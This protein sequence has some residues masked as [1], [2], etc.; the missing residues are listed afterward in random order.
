MPLMALP[1]TRQWYR[2]SPGLVNRIGFDVWAVNKGLKQFK[3]DY[4][5]WFER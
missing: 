2:Y 3:A 5:E 4:G 1:W